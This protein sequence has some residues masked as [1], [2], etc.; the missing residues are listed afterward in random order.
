MMQFEFLEAPE[1]D[2]HSVSRVA[3]VGLMVSLAAATGL[4]NYRQ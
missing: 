1:E 3:L 4:R 2:R